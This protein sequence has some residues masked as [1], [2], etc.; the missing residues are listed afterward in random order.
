MPLFE[1]ALDVVGDDTALTDL[2]LLLKVNQAVAFGDLDR[3]EEALR[4]A[5]HVRDQADNTGSLVRLAQAQSALARAAVR[6]RS[7]G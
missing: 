6:G 7:V 3:Y 1:R 2:G 5:E 4:T